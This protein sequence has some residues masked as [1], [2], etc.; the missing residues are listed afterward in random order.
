MGQALDALDLLVVIDVAMTETARHADYVL[1][2]AS[3]FE[4]CEATFFNL[5]FPRNAFHL[6]H[7]LLDP[8][9]GTLPE[10]DMYARLLRAL[11]VVDDVALEPL[12]E[13]AAEGLEA[14]AAAF[15]AAVGENP[16]L[17]AVAPYVL[18]E[19]LGSTLPEGLRGAAALWGL[20]VRV[21][22]FYPAAM[23]RAGHADANALFEAILAGKS[24]ITFTENEYEEDFD[25]IAHGDKKIALEIPELLSEVAAL[26]DNRPGWTTTDFPMVLSVGE[27]RGYTANTIY[28]DA[29][30]RK[31]DAE[32]ALRISLEDAARLGLSNGAAARITTA[33]GT[34]DAIVEVT[35]R[36]QPG[37]AS[38]PNGYGLGDGP[39]VAP[40]T[41]TSSDW[42]DPFA[43]TPWHKHV[44][45]NIT[46][47]VT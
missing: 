35:D 16:G 43:G 15:G 40:N 23:Q 5:E 4:K 19:T 13:A 42:R 41:L 17:M 3:Q 33:R 18:Y 9:E 32:G 30:W 14:F 2:A 34:A 10:P 29:A 39:G 24:G 20:A 36:M 28:R 21:S 11:G 8:L 1:P 31:R 45:A 47:S 26:R 12:R 22:M 25:Y 27:R 6:R 44:P 37:H 7:P 46:P 38:I